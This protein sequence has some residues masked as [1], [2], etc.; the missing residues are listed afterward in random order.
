MANTSYF[1][2]ANKYFTSR[3]RLELLSIDVF[4]ENLQKHV[5]PKNFLLLVESLFFW[6]EIRTNPKIV[7][8]LK[9]T[10]NFKALIFEDSFF[11]DAKIN[12]FYEQINGYISAI[13]ISF[14]QNAENEDIL[15]ELEEML[16]NNVW[17]S[18]NQ[19]KQ[20][21]KNEQKS[22]NG[23]KEMGNDFL[24]MFEAISNFKE[25][26]LNLSPKTKKEK[27]CDI[28]EQ[29]MNNFNFE[30]E[31]ETGDQETIKDLAHEKEGYSKL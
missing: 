6:E 22:A 13:S 14:D 4:Q 8:F 15:E 3:V 29:L 2:V 18:E 17:K 16:A 11:K 9:N 30:E 10:E 19:E 12:D 28:M 20:N 31:E 5:K 7:N 23:K 27:A 24:A 25:S 1:E 21:A 26:S